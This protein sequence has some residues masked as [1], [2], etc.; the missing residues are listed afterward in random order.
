MFNGIWQTDVRRFEWGFLTEA[1]D[2]QLES[3]END[4]V[5]QSMIANALATVDQTKITPS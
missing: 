5:I 2:A 1:G 4:V 3:H